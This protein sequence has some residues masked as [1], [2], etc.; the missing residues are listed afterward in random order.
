MLYQLQKVDLEIAR[1]RARLREI[2]ALLNN[3]E[4]VVQALQALESANAALKPSQAR[5]RDLDLEIKSV[6]EKA[7]STDDD[8]YSGRI[9]SAKALQELQEEAAA[10]KRQQSGLEDNLLET[11]MS[12]EEHQAAVTAALDALDTARAAQ[13]GRQTELVEEQARLQAEAAQ[14]DERRKA[15]A[16]NIEAANL[17]TY[18]KLRQRFRGQPVSLLVDE[19]CMICGVGQTSMNLK[20]V[21][22]GRALT[23]C[24]SCGRILADIS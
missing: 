1:R 11:M 6:A 8:L 15:M 14:S 10:L 16:A 18:D 5:A 23:Y 9:R 20:A 7:R 3:D 13:A 4:T 24:E 22:S 17:A 19:G 21:R 12:V 2:D